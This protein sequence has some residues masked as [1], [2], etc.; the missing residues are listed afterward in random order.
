MSPLQPNCLPLLIGSL[1]VD[2]HDTAM[3]LILEST[4]EIPGWPQLPVLPKEGMI[5]QFLPGMPAL[6][7]CGATAFIYGEGEKFNSELSSFHEEYLMI[8]ETGRP[9]LEG[10]RFTL[11]SDTAKGFFTFLKRTEQVK[12]SLQALKGQ[13]TGPF[14][15][16]TALM[17]HNNQPIYYNDSLRDAAIK[18]LALKAR[19]QIEKMKNICE[20]TIMFIDEPALA[21]FG[22]SAGV[23]GTKEDVQKCLAAVF[24]AVKSKGA[25]AGVHVCADT[26]WSLLFDAGID[27]V[28]F[29]SY[30]YFDTFILYANTLSNFFERGGILANGIVPTT[31]ELINKENAA[32]LT[33]RWFSQAEALTKTGIPLET[34]FRQTLITPSCGT[35]TISV[36]H[37]KKVLAMTREVSA[38]IREKFNL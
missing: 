23:T 3:D 24:A 16:T 36:E 2:S 17:D 11:T 22:S 20:T 14:T 35:G 18:L 15:F 32:S 19:Y 38:N 1:P 13:I 9:P 6:A 5:R 8:T 28:S 12:D 25:L 37:A 29:D 27:I 7:Y 34:V 26:E 33:R 21:G 10:S 30:G 31:T 4:P